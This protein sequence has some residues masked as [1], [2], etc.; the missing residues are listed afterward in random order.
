LYYNYIIVVHDYLYITLSSLSIPL[1][2]SPGLCDDYIKFSGDPLA[3]ILDRLLS[4]RHNRL[5]RLK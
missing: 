2:F 3:F 5:R 4:V 1:S